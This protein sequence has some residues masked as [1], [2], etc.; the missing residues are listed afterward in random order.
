[1]LVDPTNFLIK[2]INKTDNYF[3]I[4]QTSQQQ[5]RKPKIMD[6]LRQEEELLHNL[7]MIIAPFLTL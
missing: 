2:D 3:I 5:E 6:R 1:M 4:V 7:V